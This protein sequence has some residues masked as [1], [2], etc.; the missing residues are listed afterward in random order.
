MSP[1]QHGDLKSLL[2]LSDIDGKIAGILAERKKLEGG[3]NTCLASF[4][5]NQVEIAD[6]RPISQ[7][8]QAGAQVHRGGRLADAPLLVDD[9][10]PSHEVCLSGRR[11][12]GVVGIPDRC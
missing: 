3:L 9:R 6:Q 1:N 11:P 12:S 10:D 2:I 7:T 5:D 4:Q 8:R